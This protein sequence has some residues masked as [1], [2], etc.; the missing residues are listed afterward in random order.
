MRTPFESRGT[1]N[2]KLLPQ[3]LRR[4]ELAETPKPRK[5]EAWVIFLC[6]L[7]LN[8]S[9][10]I[11]FHF[12][13][14]IG[15][16][17][18]LSTTG[19]GFF[20]LFCRESILVEILVIDPPLPTF[21]Q[22]VLI[23]VLNFFGISS[24]AGPLLSAIFGALSLVILNRILLMLRLPEG[25]RWLLVALTG[26]FPV[27]LYASAVGSVEILYAFVILVIIYGAL[28]IRRN[29]MAFLICGFGLTFG[30]LVHYEIISLMIGVIIALIIFKWKVNDDWQHELEG[31]MLAFLTPPVYGIMLWTILNW[32]NV[33]SPIYFLNYL[34]DPDHA[35]SI[36]RNVGILHP[37]FLGWRNFLES[38]VIASNRIWQTSLIFTFG[39]F[40]TIYLAAVNKKR[41][42]ISVLV[43][44]LSIP[45]MQVIEISL[46]A[47]SPW[48]YIWVYLVPFG[49][50][51][52]GM[53]YQDLKPARRDFFMV[54]MLVLTVFS[55]LTNFNA[56]KE[57]DNS[58]G[59]Q[60]AYTL[61]MGDSAQE[62]KLRVSDPYWVY[63]HD[64]AIVAQALDQLTSDGNVLMDA[65]Y[66]AAIAMAL[67]KPDRLVLVNDLDMDTFYSPDVDDVSYVLV[68]Q[69]DEPI[70]SSMNAYSYPPL[71][72]EI[73]W[74]TEVWSSDE[75]LLNW[76]LFRVEID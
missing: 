71:S 61:L 76:R 69:Q 62:Q 15:S 60:R 63:Q 67:G 34:F 37:Y 28:Q 27:F 49:A 39:I 46:G 65:D 42:Y 35:T 72:D 53:V 48:L 30:F 44:M 59:E 64:S 18:A 70:N 33:D 7:V 25:Y 10:A 19:R 55:I 57:S 17:D 43:M 16:M 51:L 1:P 73:S 8:V 29:Q 4:R 56:L 20:F 6:A 13:W 14:S 26:F 2:K 22:V 68:L 45:V 23:P 5:F 32:M 52:A 40:S 31:W 36:A 66:A 58:I 9:I 11:L 12:I 75:T 41:H 38:L 74:V 3:E 47:L 21:L 54:A 50:I 24:F